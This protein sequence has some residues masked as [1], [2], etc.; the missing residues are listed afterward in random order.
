MYWPKAVPSFVLTLTTDAVVGVAVGSKQILK[1]PPS[2]TDVD[3]SRLVDTVDTD[4]P[5][6]SDCCWHVATCIINKITS[7]I[8]TKLLVKNVRQT[9]FIYLGWEQAYLDTTA[10]RLS[11]TVSYSS[12]AWSAATEITT[13][14]LQSTAFCSLTEPR[15]LVWGS[16]ALR[17]CSAPWRAADVPN[18]SHFTACPLP[19]L[20]LVDCTRKTFP[21]SCTLFKARNTKVLLYTAKMT[22]FFF[23]VFS[24]ELQSH[25]NCTL[26]CTIQMTSSQLFGAVL[27]AMW[28]ES[29]VIV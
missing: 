27:W 14:T 3:A 7:K 6:C 8:Q 25:V 16:A 24:C 28:L 18:V 5:N 23:Q 21:K 12:C 19:L 11:E 9:C 26:T 2:V 13:C 22:L 1:E 15:L 17:G 10:K 4:K 20:S 29:V